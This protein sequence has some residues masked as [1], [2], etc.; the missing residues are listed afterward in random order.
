MNAPASPP[1][2][3][4]SRSGFALLVLVLAGF[5]A[6]VMWKSAE[7]PAVVAT[8]FD[9]QGRANGWMSRDRHL[10]FT[11]ALGILTPLF[12]VGI[13]AF[14]RRRAGW[15]LNIPNKAYWLAP[16]RQT[17]TFD[18]LSRQGLWLA[19]LMAVF[20]AAIYKSLLDA[21]KL[22]PPTLATEESAWLGGGLVVLIVI[23][24]AGLLLRF[25]KPS[26]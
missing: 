17:A 23:W 16:E 22:R 18:Y 24:I 7:L 19:T 8:H 4:S 10:Y 15:G 6:Y 11:L 3:S 9:A 5:V 2:A 25:R 21:N 12:I 13:F 1:A 26:K 14:I 20:Q